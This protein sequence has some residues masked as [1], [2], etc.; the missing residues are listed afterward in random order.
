MLKRLS[1]GVMFALMCLGVA[2]LATAGH[3]HCRVKQHHRHCGCCA[4]SPCG[5]P[6]AR[7]WR[8]SCGAPAPVPAMQPAPAP[9][10][11]PKAVAPPPPA[12][13]LPLGDDPHRPKPEL[14]PFCQSQAADQ[15]GI[16]PDS[17]F[18]TSGR[19]FADRTKRG[20]ATQ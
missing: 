10:P 20:Q 18:R 3:C 4:V 14:S 2:P 12:A 19:S 6:C 9:A 13:D 8:L 1:V 7:R 15:T 16:V 17:Q 5:S 11:A